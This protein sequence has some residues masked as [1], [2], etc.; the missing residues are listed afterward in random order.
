M[1]CINI[2][3]NACRVVALSLVMITSAFALSL[4]DAKSQ[5]LIG[6]TSSGYIA[7]V[8]S[9]GEVKALVDSINSQRKSHYRN[10]AKTNN[11]SMEAVEVRAGQKAIRK[12]AAGHYVNTGG[13]WQKK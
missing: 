13:G 1:D 10:I 12:T 11:I 9:S 6:E 8:K 3:K 4:G 2:V 5:G 7:A